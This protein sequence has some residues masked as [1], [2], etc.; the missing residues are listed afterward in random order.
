[1]DHV[2]LIQL[3]IMKLL[4]LLFGYRLSRRAATPADP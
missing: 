2:H 4:L 1:M 3:I